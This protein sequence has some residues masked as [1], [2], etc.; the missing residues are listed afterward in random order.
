MSTRQRERML[1]SVSKDELMG[2]PGSLLTPRLL[3]PG[4]KG[5]LLM[6]GGF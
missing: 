4:T 3:L 1:H 5:I 6:G 2:H